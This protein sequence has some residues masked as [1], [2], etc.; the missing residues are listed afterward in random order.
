MKKLKKYPNRGEI[1]ELIVSKNVRSKGIGNMLM[2][3]IEEYFKSF[4][5]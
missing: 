1:T 2:N 5:L 3:K 4:R